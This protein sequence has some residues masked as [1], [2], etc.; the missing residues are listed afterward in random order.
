MSKYLN[1]N[2]LIFISIIFIFTT[3][4]YYSYSD[5]LLFGGAD[6]QDYYLIAQNFPS[7]AENSTGHH[8]TWRFL[9][10]YLI[11]FL[12]K[13]FDLNIFNLFQYATF[14]L[15]LL[16]IIL[17][18]K[19]LEILKL[20]KFNIFFLLSFVIF[21]PYFF[22]YYIVIPTMINDIIFIN[23]TFLIILGYLNNNKFFLYMGIA[24]ATLVRQN[25]ILLLL[26]FIVTKIFFKKKSL[27]KIYDIFLITLIFISIFS[28]NNYFADNSTINND[29]FSISNRFGLFTT[30]Y[31]F[32]QLIKFHFYPLIIILPLFSYI[33]LEK[34]KNHFY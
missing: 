16:T 2:Y 20:S 13:T 31:N 24:I 1:I 11:G 8:R 10:P 5:S 32:I 12:S 29:S 34:K 4:N 7:F 22:R 26:T 23:S 33:Y 3:N 18:K 27:L 19:L 28:I 21:N 15:L 14:S 25:S 17:F 9:F 30:E 6:G